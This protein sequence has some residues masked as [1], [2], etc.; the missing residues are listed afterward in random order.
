MTERIAKKLLHEMTGLPD[1]KRKARF[2][3]CIAIASGDDVKNLFGYA[4]GKI[5]GF[6]MAKKGSGMTSFL[7]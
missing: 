5:G 6:R 3:C 1:K 7:S 2:A 4:E